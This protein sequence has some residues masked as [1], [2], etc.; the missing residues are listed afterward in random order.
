LSD[1]NVGTGGINAGEM[2]DL[3]QN[4]VYMRIAGMCVFA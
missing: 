4:N 2:G 1:Y 3:V